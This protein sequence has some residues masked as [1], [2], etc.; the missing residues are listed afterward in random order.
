MKEDS[1]NQ[2]SA[3]IVTERYAAYVGLDVHK[4]TI[5][6][7]VALPGR[8]EPL[9]RG[10]IAHEPKK[11]SRWLDRLSAEFEGALL[12]FC[13]EAG[14]C[15]Y[16][17]YRRLVA[18]GH[19]CQ[20]VAPSLIPKKAGE[21][22]KTDRRDALKLARLLRAGELTPVWVPDA[23]QEAMRDLTRARD[24]MKGQERKA[25][26][27]LNGFLLRHGHHWPTGKTRWTA[28]HFNWM[29]SI[30]FEQPWLQV[31]LQE[32]I[33]AVKAA[34]R[35][36][37]D[38]TAQLMQ[39]LPNWSLAPVVDALVA[40]R[41]IDTLAAI[42]LLAELG[43]LSRFE[44]PTQ[45]MASPG[46]VPSEH[47]RGRRR[48]HGAIPPTGHA[49]ARRMLVECAWS[50]RFPARQTMHLK[51]KAKAAPEQAKAIAWR[52]QKRLCGRYRTLTQAGKNV[53]RVCVAIARELAGFIWDIVRQEM[54]RLGAGNGMV[55]R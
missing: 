47:R 40:L 3:P 54:P 44:S 48:R 19:D 21:R 17:L 53:K 18:A 30:R 52:A 29:A 43:D 36:V 8:D 16:G 22:V 27:Q 46:R 15:G 49:H 28:T 24:D 34:S 32:Y 38:L 50:Y 31:V 13:Y 7:A 51:R 35:R 4:D 37:A 55:A 45:L 26:Q 12:Q 23:E 9:Y 14:P 5:A 11:V 41:G 1:A 2:T 10:E 42:V 33:D 39:A 25:R 20:V 6:V